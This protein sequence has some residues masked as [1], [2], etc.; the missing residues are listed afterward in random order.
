MGIDGEAL[1]AC[2]VLHG[3][4][5]TMYTTQ[6]K[7]CLWVDA[8]HK[9]FGFMAECVQMVFEGFSKDLPLLPFNRRFQNARHPFY[10]AVYEGARTLNPW[11]ADR[12]DTCIIK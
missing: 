4:D 6:I 1:F 2:T 10:K 11:L 9:E 8:D 5:H 12:M 3:L 7:D